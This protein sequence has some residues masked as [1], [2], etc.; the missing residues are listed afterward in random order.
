MYA[1]PALQRLRQEELKFTISLVKLGDLAS[2]PQKKKITFQS[3]NL[4]SYSV[5]IN[6]GNL[7]TYRKVFVRELVLLMIMTYILY[8]L[9]AQELLTMRNWC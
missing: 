1:T 6:L 4:H 7:S 8:H 3:V 5:N 2:P 9:L